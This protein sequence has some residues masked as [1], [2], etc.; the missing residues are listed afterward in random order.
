MQHI[1]LTSGG[2]CIAK[3]ESKPS[4]ASKPDAFPPPGAAKSFS[5]QALNEKL[6]EKKYRQKLNEFQIQKNC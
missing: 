6:K 4:S 3:N 5:P 1:S 2:A